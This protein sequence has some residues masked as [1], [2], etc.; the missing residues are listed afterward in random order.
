MFLLQKLDG[1][2]EKIKLGALTIFRQLINTAGA[3]MDNKKEL[4]ISGLKTVL[5]DNNNK[6]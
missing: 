3:A 2:T 4:L 1:S 6:V 5:S